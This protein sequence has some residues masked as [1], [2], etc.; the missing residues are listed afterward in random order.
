MI[1]SPSERRP[2][3]Y[4]AAWGGARVDM[5]APQS[6]ADLHLR[7]DRLVNSFKKHYKQILLL[8]QVR[9]HMAAVAAQVAQATT[10]STHATRPPRLTPSDRRRCHSRRPLPLLSPR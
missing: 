8:A 6:A 1:D 7:A 3:P 10:A 9:T 4:R 5:A 2:P